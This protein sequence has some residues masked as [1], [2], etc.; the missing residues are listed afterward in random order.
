MVS[1]LEKKGRRKEGREE[2]RK[3]RLEFQ[4]EHET[5]V[6]M[7]SCHGLSVYSWQVLHSF[8]ICQI[9]ILPYQ[10]CKVVGEIEKESI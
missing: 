3:E 10:P 5:G 1:T 9:F 2:G 8:L 6:R 4:E 7:I